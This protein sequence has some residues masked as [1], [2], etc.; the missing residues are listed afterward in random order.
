MAKVTIDGITYE[1][2]AKEIRELFEEFGAEFPVDAD[3]STEKYVKGDYVRVTKDVNEHEKGDVL[4]I[5][6]VGTRPLK[7]A[8]R[9]TRIYPI[10]A[11]GW[12][13]YIDEENFE[14]I[15]YIEGEAKVGD[16]ILITNR[17]KN[18]KR[19]ENG[20]VITVKRV[21]WGG[22]ILVEHNGRSMAILSFEFEIIERG[23]VKESQDLPV[24]TR[25]K[26]KKYGHLYTLNG[27][28]PEKDTAKYGRAYRLKGKNS[29]YGDKQFEVITEEVEEIAEIAEKGDIIRLVQNSFGFAKGSI[30]EVVSGDRDDNLVAVRDEYG[31]EH[32]ALPKRYVIVAKKSDRRDV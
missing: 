13:G 14:P 3:E 25:V 23:E 11:E 22:H 18:E 9:N 30:H 20:D 2:T 6:N 21:G 16:K 19:F 32:L 1:G 12:T 4:E 10:K 29:W 7:Y 5:I 24:G 27:R 8:V 17:Y 31:G 15:E 28:Y 26:S